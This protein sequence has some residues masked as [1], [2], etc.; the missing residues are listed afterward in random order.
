M[1]ALP[2]K[3]Q[4]TPL[5]RNLAAQELNSGLSVEK[6]ERDA[7]VNTIFANKKQMKKF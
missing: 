7:M 5:Q 6:K 3:K 1:Q 2:V 4:S